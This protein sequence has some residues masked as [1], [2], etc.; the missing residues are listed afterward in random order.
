MSEEQQEALRN[1]LTGVLLR[2]VAVLTAAL[3][4]YHIF[5]FGALTGY[6][7]LTG[8]YIYGLLAMISLSVVGALQAVGI[9]LAIAF[10]IAP[11]ATAFLV[12]RRFG[13]M[14]AV[15][16]ASAAFSAV[17]GV[18]L[19]FF[20]DSAPAPTIVLVMTGLFIAAFAWS[21]A[22]A[23]QQERAAAGG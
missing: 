23:G 16:V 1:P 22:M 18:Y 17:A 2:I 4:I 10:L 13:A 15:A 14:L 12:T 9:I 21:T 3:A 19:S 7:M 5:N 20:I 6:T 8:E 11:G